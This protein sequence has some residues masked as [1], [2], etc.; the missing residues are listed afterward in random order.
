[1]KK[2]LFFSTF[3]IA[4]TLSAADTLHVH[5]PE[6]FLH[7]IGPNRVLLIE[8]DTIQLREI[9]SLAAIPE[10]QEGTYTLLEPYV[11]YLGGNGMVVK[12]VEDMKII[13]IPKFSTH[14]VICTSDYDNT[15]MTFRDCKNI[16]MQNMEFNHIPHSTGG[17]SGGVLFF[18]NCL[19]VD[20]VRCSLIGS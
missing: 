13:G 19:S 11:F 5:S 8:T 4:A 2:L 15:I 18:D 10:G 17:C 3:L 7:A 14:C 16:Y 9:S 20:I 6:E 1:M 12:G